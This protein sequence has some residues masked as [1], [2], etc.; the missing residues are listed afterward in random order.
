MGGLFLFEH[1]GKN[2]EYKPT[3]ALWKK[4]RKFLGYAR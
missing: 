2:Y 4:T 1:I 3:F